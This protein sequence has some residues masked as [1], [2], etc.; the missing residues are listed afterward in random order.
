MIQKNKNKL[1][2]L[3]EEVAS[4]YL[5]KQGYKII[6]RNF[7]KRYEEIDIIAKKSDSLIFVEVKTRIGDKFGPIEESISSY[8]IYNLKK[9]INYYLHLHPTDIK[10][11]Q[12]DFIGIELFENYQIKKI[13][14]YKAIG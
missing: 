1:G 3:G 4:N 14:H 9:S 7:H 11:I 12:L 10:K 2:F 6:L 13:S 5:L 8:K